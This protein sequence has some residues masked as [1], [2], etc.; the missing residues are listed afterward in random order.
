MTTYLNSSLTT[1][2][3]QSETSVITHVT[4]ECTCGWFHS[5]K[6]S[7]LYR[8]MIETSSSVL[9]ILTF[10]ITEIYKR[11]VW[12]WITFQIQITR[13]S[14]PAPAV[15]CDG[16]QLWGDTCWDIRANILDTVCDRQVKATECFKRPSVKQGSKVLS[17]M[18]A[19]QTQHTFTN[20]TSSVKGYND[21]F[22]FTTQLIKLNMGDGG[23]LV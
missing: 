8:F 10:S 15:W 13:S 12:H 5:G 6:L 18:T 14:F 17:A 20:M 2:R 3:Q 4:S 21:R 11:C 23:K 22:R 19:T 1:Q 16:T 9:Q 7:R